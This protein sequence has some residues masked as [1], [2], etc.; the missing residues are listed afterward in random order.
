MSP[1]S[2]EELKRLK[3]ELVALVENGPKADQETLRIAE[4]LLDT[5]SVGFTPESRVMRLGTLLRV[6]IRSW[7]S[8]DYG[9]S[10]AVSER[11]KSAMLGAIGQLTDLVARQRFN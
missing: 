2:D 8:E 7:F 6:Q 11:Q 4:A 1:I 10:A 5:L 9:R 3:S